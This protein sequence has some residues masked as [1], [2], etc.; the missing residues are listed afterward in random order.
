MGPATIDNIHQQLYQNYLNRQLLNDRFSERWLGV[1]YYQVQ[2]MKILALKLNDPQVNMP[3][4]VNYL[5]TATLAPLDKIFQDI[6]KGR[7]DKFQQGYFSSPK[8][9]K[10]INNRW[11]ELYFMLRSDKQDKFIQELKNQDLSLGDLF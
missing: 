2:M 7:L 8:D 6:Y 9:N 3:K 4:G 10:Q 5:S 1:L 11:A